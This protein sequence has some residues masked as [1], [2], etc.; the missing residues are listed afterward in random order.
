MLRHAARAVP[1][2]LVGAAALLI[3]GLL[4][5]VRYD[6]WTLWPLQGTAVGLLAGAVGWCLDEPAAAVVDPA[7]RGL[8]WRTAAR[9][10]GIVVLLAA[11]SGA[12]WWAR[13]ALFGHASTVLA[14]GLTA[15]AVATAWVTWRRS[16]GEA[17]PGQRWATVVVPVV[18]A[19]A[20]VRP[21]EEH[22]PVF[23]YAFSGW[24][25]SIIGWSTAGIGAAVLLMLGAAGPA[26]RVR[27]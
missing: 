21:F 17:T 25:T 24:D 9:A 7:P 26:R 15:A 10:S 23:P 12:V 20:L 6:N 2:L 11:W 3:V 22:I 27:R 18:T 1:W 13:D 19:W 8:A 5:A 14:Q 16:A 4:A